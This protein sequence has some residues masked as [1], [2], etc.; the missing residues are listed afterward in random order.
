MVILKQQFITDTK[1]DF[2]RKERRKEE[3]NTLYFF[4]SF[5]L[6]P[7]LLTILKGSSIL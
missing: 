2:V 7:Q 5:F 4:L 6:F 3:K 1:S